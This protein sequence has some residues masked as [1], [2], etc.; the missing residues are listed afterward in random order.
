MRS[1]ALRHLQRRV[2]HLI[3]LALLVGIFVLLAALMGK[4]AFED[5]MPPVITCPSTETVYTP[6]EDTSAL[7]EGVTAEDEQDGDVTE[8]VRVRSISIAEDEATAI[9]T[10]VARDQANN[11]G[12]EKRVVKVEAGE[13]TEE[14]AEEAAEETPAEESVS[15][16]TEG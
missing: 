5:V 2:T 4:T 15:E 9:V 3:C 7:L 6:G 10:Y 14:I 16:E 11:M 12:L 8:S 1:R 13:A